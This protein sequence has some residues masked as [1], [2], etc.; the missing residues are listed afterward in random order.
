MP[1]IFSEAGFTGRFYMA[2]LNEPIH[3]H[4]YKD[5]KEAK[6]WASPISCASTGGFSRQEL[7]RAEALIEKYL[8]DLLMLWHQTEEARNNAGRAS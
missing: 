3:I 4:V 6:F 1:R 5:G 8:H 2:D 7:Q